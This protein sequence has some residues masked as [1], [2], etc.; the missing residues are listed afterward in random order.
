MKSFG[1]RLSPVEIESA[2][3]TAPGVAEVAVVGVDVEAGK[4]LVTA[5]VIEESPGST[6]EAALQ[7]HA[8]EH[9][10]EYKRPHQYRVVESLPRTRNGKLQR[11]AL[12]AELLGE[13]A[14]GGLRNRRSRGL[15]VAGR[16]RRTLARRRASGFELTPNRRRGTVLLF[17]G[18]LSLSTAA[19]TGFWLVWWALQPRD[20]AEAQASVVHSRIYEYPPAWTGETAHHGWDVEVAVEHTLGGATYSGSVRGGFVPEYS[21]RAVA[22]AAQEGLQPGTSLDVLYSKT[23]PERVRLPKRSAE[24]LNRQPR[25]DRLLGSIVA[26]LTALGVVLIAV[27]SHL[28]HGLAITGRRRGAGS[29]L[30]RH[31]RLSRTST[32]TT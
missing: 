22:T 21:R 13:L 30:T 32:T 9:L 7:A 14:A 28:I 20:W 18:V 2:L 8:A 1:Y 6:S 4:T 15:A 10:A 25:I 12:V 16:R 17:L 29:R 26:S 27:E 19:L 5:C 24:E 11:R 23:Q 3:E 31:V